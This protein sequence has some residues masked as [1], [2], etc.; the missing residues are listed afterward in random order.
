MKIGA[1]TWLR[2]FRE[3]TNYTHV[4]HITLVHNKKPRRRYRRT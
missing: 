3:E 1:R 2:W 4:W